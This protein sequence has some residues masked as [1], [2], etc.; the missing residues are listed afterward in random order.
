MYPIDTSPDLIVS[1]QTTELSNYAIGLLLAYLND[2]LAKGEA[3]TANSPVIAP[4][5]EHKYGRGKNTG[6]PFLQTRHISRLIREALR[7]RFH[8]RPYVF[9]AFFDT[10]LLIAESKGKIAHDFRIFF[11]GHKGSIEA[12]YT[13]NKGVLSE[14]LINEMCEAFK[15]SETLLDLEVNEEDPLL[16]QK[17]QIINAVSKA[18]P[19]KVQEM[20][21]MLGVCNT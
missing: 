20:L 9:R 3:L 7:P 19:E 14:G 8:W 6:K 1:I 17:E 10:Q 13:T 18:A 16:K 2:R 12:K 15:R 5:S 21:G 11:M 4:D